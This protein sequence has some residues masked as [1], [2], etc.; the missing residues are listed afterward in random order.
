MGWSEKKSKPERERKLS[1]RV[2]LSLN[3]GVNERLHQESK[4]LVA[5]FWTVLKELTGQK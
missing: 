1:V 5:G 3:A 2:Q 4:S